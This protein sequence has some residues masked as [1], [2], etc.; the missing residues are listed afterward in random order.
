MPLSHLGSLALSSIVPGVDDAVAMITAASTELA[1]MK[2]SQ[3]SEL[4]GLLGRIGGM[5]DMLTSAQALATSAQGLLNS[6]TLVLEQCDTL[7]ANLA[8]A[9]SASG[10]HLYAYAGEVGELSNEV[11]TALGS[12][13]P[14]GSGAAQECTGLLIITTDGGAWS[15]IQQVLRTS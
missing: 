10:I 2:L 3:E 4:N 6:A 13:I 7:T 5:T 9:L 11:A 1:A 14:G 15:A 12:G 8:A